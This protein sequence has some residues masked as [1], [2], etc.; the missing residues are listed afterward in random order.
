MKPYTLTITGDEQGVVYRA[1]KAGLFAAKQQASIHVIGAIE[2]VR[3]IEDALAIMNRVP[4]GGYESDEER[5][6]AFMASAAA[7]CAVHGCD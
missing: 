3:Q 2:I 6:A 5:S 1:L 4:E 7:E